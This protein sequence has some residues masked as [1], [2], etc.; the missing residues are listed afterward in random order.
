MSENKNANVNSLG[1]TQEEYKK[2]T[3]NAWV[4]LLAFSVLYCFLYCGRLNLQYTMP[5]MMAEEGW[6]ELDLG[7]LSSV[8][9]WTY[10]IGHLFNGRLGEIF[11]VNRFIIAGMFLSAAA[12]LL[13]GF[14]SSIIIIAILWGFN[15]YFQAMLW[16]PGIALLSK[17]WPGDKRG[18][19]TGFANA[20]SGFGQVAAALTVSLAFII[21]P[22]SGWKAGF[23]VPVVIMVVVA[24]IYIFLAKDSPTKIG[25]KEYVDPDA[26]RNE[27][28]L[29]LQKMI[30]E[31]GKLFPYLYLF[32]K[33]R[34]DCWLLIIA[35]SSIARY[36][37]LTWIPTYYVQEFGV[38]IE[39][40][41]LGTVLLPLGMAFGTLIIPWISDKFFSENRL[42]MVV[43]CAG[44]AGVTVFFFMRVEPGALAGAMLF[45]AGFFIYAINGLVWAYATDVGGR[46]F[47]GTAA[48]VLDCFAYL[49]AS[50]Q[51]IFF[52]SVLT[53]SGNW[54][55][56]FTAIAGVCIAII[57]IAIIAGWGLNKKSS[58]DQSAA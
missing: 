16:S 25:L 2:F 27:Q 28:D 53:N 50:V 42:P 19:A 44:V 24:I 33:W 43:I 40:G 49:G 48:G 45:I 38:D 55:L 22:G 15:G 39:E 54:T 13:I 58:K 7:I 6:T 9:F 3:K 23:I 17:W 20:F 18:F 32:K 31:N 46:A 35:G 30:A 5:A 57:V 4:V 41:A 34:F 51:A 1:Y 21:M 52:G 56:V 10:G 12:N 8:L 29:E 26:K 14:Q 36:G 37:L 47:A 11:G